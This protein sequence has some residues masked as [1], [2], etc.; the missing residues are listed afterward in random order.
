MLTPR[1]AFKVGF[2]ARCAEEGLSPAQIQ[3]RVKLAR[4]K[5]AGVLDS[6]G[7]AAGSVFST[8]APLA[9]IAPPALGAIAGYGLSRAT[10]IDDTDVDEIKNNELLDTYANETAKL[11]R[12]KAVRDFKSQA[13]APR[14]FGI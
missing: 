3:D 8:G 12:Q 6:L 14:Q 13:K 2:L 5:F 11:R 9:L 4:D 10:D 1:E 7:H